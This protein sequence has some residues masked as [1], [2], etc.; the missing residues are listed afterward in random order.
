MLLWDWA[1]WDKRFTMLS[2][3]VVPSAGGM[4]AVGVAALAANALCLLLLYKHKDDDINMRST[5]LCSRNDVL[6]NLGVML[7]AALVLWLGSPWPDIV[8]GGVIA[9]MILI[10][11]IGILRE[12]LHELKGKADPHDLSPGGY[13]VESCR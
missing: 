7:A 4:G 11:S 8:I 10:S 5:W 3:G 9:A 6:A 12:A 1:F 13:R 2:Q